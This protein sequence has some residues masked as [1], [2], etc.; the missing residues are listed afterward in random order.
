LKNLTLEFTTPLTFLVGE[1]GSGK[2]TLLEA[3]A[4]LCRLPIGGGGRTEL[5]DDLKNERPRSALR[6]RCVRAF[7]SAPGTATSCERRTS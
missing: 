3:I 7:A 2:T 1:N 4:D 6:R 5:A